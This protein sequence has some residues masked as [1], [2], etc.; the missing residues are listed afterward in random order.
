MMGK[1]ST[2]TSHEIIWSTSCTRWVRLQGFLGLL[3]SI[4]GVLVNN[5]D[6]I[7]NLRPDSVWILRLVQFQWNYISL[8]YTKSSFNSFVCCCHRKMKKQSKQSLVIMSFPTALALKC[9]LSSKCT[10][11]LARE[12]H[13][14]SHEQRLIFSVSAAPAKTLQTDVMFGLIF[15][16]R[17][18]DH[19]LFL[20]SCSL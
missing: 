19:Q 3:S 18:F 8:P 13:C 17:S 7:H 12:I 5:R 6:L 14:L 16:Y 11:Y 4:F 2:W 20:I 15:W 9:M 1:R 10:N